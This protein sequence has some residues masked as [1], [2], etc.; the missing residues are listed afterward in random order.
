MV[1]KSPTITFWAY[2]SQP[3]YY[4]SFSTTTTQL[5]FS[6][7]PFGHF[8]TILQQLPKELPSLITVDNTSN[9]S[10]PMHNGPLISPP[11]LSHDQ[12]PA[13][14]HPCS[15]KGR[16]T[17]LLLK[18]T[19]PMRSWESSCESQIVTTCHIQFWPSIILISISCKV[20]LLFLSLLLCWLNNAQS[21]S[22][23]SLDLLL[24]CLDAITIW[25]LYSSQWAF[26]AA[27]SIFMN[28]S[29]A[30]EMNISMTICPGIFG[31]AWPTGTPTSWECS[32]SIL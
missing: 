12:C 6:L 31:K 2:T 29:L 5:L 21:W 4:H 15:P 9:A 7:Y 20:W 26:I 19:L 1:D 23:V 16:A 11:V 8:S 28:A 3:C 24:Y 13:S 14:L 32:L 25:S 18:S 27:V 10:S 22:S 17:E 30:E